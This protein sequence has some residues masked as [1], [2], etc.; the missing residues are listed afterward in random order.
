MR[1]GFRT[2]KIQVNIC[3]VFFKNE[4]QS[5][6][7]SS[8]Y[9]EPYPFQEVPRFSLGPIQ[10]RSIQR[11]LASVKICLRWWNPTGPLKNFPKEEKDEVD[12]DADISGDE[13]ISHP[14]L[15]NIETVKDDN[16]RKKG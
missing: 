12:W 7:N 5:L 1:G 13:I 2:V 9:P 14:W 11:G 8:S 15:E 16:Y 4:H 3:T 10:I 6:C